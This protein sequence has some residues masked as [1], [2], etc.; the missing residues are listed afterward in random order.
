MPS[1]QYEPRDYRSWTKIPD[2]ITFQ[3][4]ELETDLQ[5][6]ACKNLEMEALSA[7]RKYRNHLERYIKQYPVFKSSMKPI[8]VASEA[9]D[10]IQKMAQAGKLAG[11]GP[12]AAVAGAMAESVGKYLEEFSPEVIVEN[13]GDIYLNCLV[14]R[15]VAIYAG[16][17]PFSGKLGL[18]ISKNMFPLGIC[19]SSG[20]VGHSKSFGKADAVIILSQDTSLADAMATSAANLIQTEQ[21]LE[22]AIEFASSVNDILGVIAIKNNNI[23][24]WGDVEFVKLSR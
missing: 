21:D 9:D 5:I 14:D 20:T 11:V 4:V 17:S 18:K 2:L 24:A 19:T 8:N 16:N 7:I 3:A 12:F 1:N 10:I 22:K 23:A 15:V 6:S 13:G